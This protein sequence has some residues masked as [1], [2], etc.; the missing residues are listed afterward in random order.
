M[1][2]DYDRPRRSCVPWTYYLDDCDT[3]HHREYAD[4]QHVGFHKGQ[5]VR[6]GSYTD[7]NDGF[8]RRVFSRN[9]WNRGRAYMQ[10]KYPK[11][12]GLSKYQLYAIEQ[13]LAAKL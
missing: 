3:N 11:K 12:H 6:D 13:K 9:C 8:L 2:T 1:K 5:S 7:N 4:L 10:G